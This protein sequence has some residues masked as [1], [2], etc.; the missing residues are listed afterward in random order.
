MKSRKYKFHYPNGHY[1]IYTYN[2]KVHR[3]DG[4]AVEMDDF[5]PAASWYLNGVEISRDEWF[6]KIFGK[7]NYYKY[8]FGRNYV[9]SRIDYSYLKDILT[10]LDDVYNVKLSYHHHFFGIYFN[11]P[12]DKDCI[13]IRS[14]LK[15]L[16]DCDVLFKINDESILIYQFKDQM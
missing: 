4:P 7:W 12:F 9:S 13:E 5:D 3:E 14:F 15:R 10:D 16:E 6:K 11:A 2:G 8:F 1:S